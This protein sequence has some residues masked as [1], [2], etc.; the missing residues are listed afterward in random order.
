VVRI[1]VPPLR[2]H[3]EDIPALAGAFCDEDRRRLGLGPVRLSPDALDQL[4]SH[5]WPGNVRELENS[6]ARAVLHASARV[7][8]GD[9]VIVRAADVEPGILQPPVTGEARAADRGG[10]APAPTARASDFPLREGKS[11]REAVEDYQRATIRAAVVESD[12]NWAAAA[13]ALGMQ[14]SNLHHL[15]KRLGLRESKGANPRTGA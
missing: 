9:A 1:E 10:V 8:R 13:R 11:L 12:G 14:R 3:R 4:A 5:T 6:I 15:A 2:Q 7:P